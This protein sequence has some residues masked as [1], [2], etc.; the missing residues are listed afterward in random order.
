MKSAQD[1]KETLRI[2]QEN[3]EV[4]QTY[5]LELFPEL[6]ELS[7]TQANA[8]LTQYDLDTII[9]GLDSALIKVNKVDHAVEDGRV[10][11][12]KMDATR[13]IK[14]A[15]MCMRNTG[16]TEE[17]RQAKDEAAKALR[18]KRSS[19]G[20]LGNAKRWHSEPQI[21][22]VCDDLPRYT[23]TGT[24]SG[25]GTYTGTDTTTDRGT[26]AVQSEKKNEETPKPKP[27]PSPVSS[28][29]ANL[30]PTPKPEEAKTLSAKLTPVLRKCPK[31]GE[32]WSRDK[33]HAC[34]ENALPCT[35][36]V[37]FY[38]H[39]EHYGDCPHAK[40]AKAASALGSVD[41]L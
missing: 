33:R 28:F 1:I 27:T 4:I 35:C 36:E 3:R 20:K 11:G 13:V 8:W 17:E 34:A 19:A 31:C 30:E 2:R 38:G 41:D 32:P 26:F 18:A 14:Y 7:H 15:S 39:G 37:A 25:T 10:K 5:W 40:K 6:G 24:G 23:G 22:T 9:V 12:G 16:L 29:S 21:A